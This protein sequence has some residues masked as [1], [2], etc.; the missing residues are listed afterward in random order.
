MPTTLWHITHV[1]NLAAILAANG[2]IAYNSL[3]SGGYVNIA[4]EGI[5]VR[6]ERKRVPCGPR[7]TL[8]E[9]VPFYFAPRSPMLY[10]IDKGGVPGYEGGQ[11]PVIYL[12]TTAEVVRDAGCAFVFS[13]GHAIME[14]S[15][16]YE[17][18]GDVGKLDWDILNGQFWFDTN[19]YPDR[20]RRRQ[21]EFLVWQKFPWPLVQEIGVK[22]ERMRIRVE[23]VLAGA[24]YQPA[25]R[26][27]RGWYY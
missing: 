23:R 19:A 27:R 25:V 26:V 10:L 6:R 15:Q 14:P 1:E 7:G 4:D 20:K 13:D 8:H 22:T 5:Q 11:E 16:F 18:L 21:A 24:D 9:Y 17:D 12:K 3:Q 2:L